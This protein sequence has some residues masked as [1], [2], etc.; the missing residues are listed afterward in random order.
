M[1]FWDDFQR[2]FKKS[3]T[4]VAQKTD[5]YTKIGKIKVDIIAIKRDIDKRYN[6]LGNKVYDMLAVEKNSKVS[7]NEDVK[8]IVQT[9][10]ELNKKLEQKKVELEEVRKEYGVSE[11][12]SATEEPVTDVEVEEVKEE[13]TEEAKG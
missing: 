4:V 6:Q 1:G 12:E 7:T 8:T 10:N 11:E 3:V 2:I 5:E 13:A 9:I